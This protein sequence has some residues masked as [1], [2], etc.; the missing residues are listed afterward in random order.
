MK[1]QIGA[2]TIV[3]DNDILVAHVTGLM[4]L[5]Q[6]KEFLDVCAK[7]L[8]QYGSVYLISI[9]GP[10]YTISPDSRRYIAEWGR[11]HKMDGNLVVGAPFAMRAV[12]SVIS[13]AAKLFGAKNPDLVFA[14]SEAE[15]RR[16]IAQHKAQQSRLS[17]SHP[18][19]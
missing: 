5:D 16:W 1:V 6:M 19:V 15:A 11:E 4:T 9:M 10:G 3:S 17:G 13:R 14:A 2:H 12:L 18:N 7:V 8:A